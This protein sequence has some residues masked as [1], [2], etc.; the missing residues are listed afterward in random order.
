MEQFGT[1][2]GKT[3]GRDRPALADRETSSTLNSYG[4]GERG[5]HDD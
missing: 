4:E 2:F 3:T 1:V 5:F